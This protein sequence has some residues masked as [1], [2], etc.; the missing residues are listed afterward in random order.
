MRNTNQEQAMTQA[1]INIDG[2]YVAICQG[3]QKIGNAINPN[4]ETLA[5][6]LRALG[7][8]AVLFESVAGKIDQLYRAAKNLRG[9]NAALSNRVIQLEDQLAHARELVDSQNR[10]LA[11]LKGAGDGQ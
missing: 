8:A 5:A 7:A 6:G 3:F 11:Q 10:E 9:E 1:P 2:E 4:P